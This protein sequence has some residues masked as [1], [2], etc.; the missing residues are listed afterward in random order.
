MVR[1]I[2]VTLIVIGFISCVIISSA[3]SQVIGNIWLLSGII[4]LTLAGFNFLIF[5]IMRRHQQV[6]RAE[7]IHQTKQMLDD[8]VK[9]QL[10]IISVNVQLA[11]PEQHRL[12]RINAAIESICSTLDVMSD[13]SLECWKSKYE[14]V[15]RIPSV[16][17]LSD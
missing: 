1:C 15:S 4:V 2:E 7:T 8:V 11:R 14:D 9:N 12:E 5:W 17:S 16:H 6:V 10:S 3:L 13:E